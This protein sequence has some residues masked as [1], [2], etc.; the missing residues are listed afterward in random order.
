MTKD[1]ITEVAISGT[2]LALL[3][4]VAYFVSPSGPST[5]EIAVQQQRLQ[6]AQVNLGRLRQV[7]DL[8]SLPTAWQQINLELSHC[9]AQTLPQV[10]P[11]AD[12]ITRQGNP[13]FWLGAF[14][15]KDAGVAMTCFYS[16]VQRY[17]IKLTGLSVSP[18]GLNVRYRL[19]GLIQPTII[20]DGP[21][22]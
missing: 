6:N 17:P 11:A 18:E 7:P 8:P 19:Y 3:L 20:T 12:D 21:K 14:S 13:P 10:Q 5:A 22:P 2:V 15:A 9:G 1:F 16:L 4:T